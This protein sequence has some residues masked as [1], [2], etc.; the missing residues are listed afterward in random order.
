VEACNELVINVKAD[1]LQNYLSDLLLEI[2]ERPQRRAFKLSSDTTQFASALTTLFADRT[3]KNGDSA[4]KVAE[5][6]A[7]RLLNVEIKT[8]ARYGHLK[9]DK[10]LLN[11]GSFLQFVFDDDSG[12]HYL[13]VKVE[14]QFF[15]D[16]SDFSRR[17]GIGESHKIYKACKVSF[18]EQGKIGEVLIFDTN[19]SPSAYWWEDFWELVELRT[20]SYN[21]GL[22]V[23]AVVKALSSLKQHAPADYTILRNATVAAF[24]GTGIMKFD[25][26][27]SNVFGGY[28]LTQESAKSRFNEI[29]KKLR[30]L[31]AT[32]KFDGE[33]N[34]VPSSVPFRK[35]TLPL[36]S[37]ISMTFDEDMPNIEDKIWASKTVDGKGV[38]VVEAD[39]A[40]LK[41]FKLKPMV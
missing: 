14:H 36:T 1:A 17:A 12:M 6:L 27:V 20:D 26:F 31:P 35:L 37:E 13:G 28:V 41:K 23:K 33:F 8:E 9:G 10:R 29:V 34:L 2:Q 39:E 3:L 21:T 22:A 38:V 4:S 5:G 25:D 19:S 11:K 18:G 7:K 16:E 15:L 24:R 32:K 40:A 30:A